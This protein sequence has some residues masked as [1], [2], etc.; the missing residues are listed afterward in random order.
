[1]IKEMIETITKE[2]FLK[3]KEIKDNGIIPLYEIY[4]IVQ[5]TNLSSRI[6]M[7]MGD[8]Y[9]ELLNKFTGD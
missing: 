1:M 3:Y 4:N 5:A 6:I 8:N 7:F 2:D 9:A